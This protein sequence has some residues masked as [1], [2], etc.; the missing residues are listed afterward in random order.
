VDETPAM[1]QLHHDLESI[2]RETYDRVRELTQEFRGDLAAIREERRQRRIEAHDKF[3]AMS[4]H[5]AGG[6]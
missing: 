2:E 6:E 4:R 5:P 3:M 1:K